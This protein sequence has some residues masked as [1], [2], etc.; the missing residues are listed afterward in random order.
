MGEIPE[1]LNQHILEAYPDNVCLVATNQ[2]DGYS[3]V[4]PRGSVHVVDQD[5]LGYWDRGAGTTHE[6]VQTGTKV[7]V[8][9]RN[10]A[11]GG[12][13]KGLLPAGGIARFYGVA[14]VH[15]E[16][17]EIREKVWNGMIEVEREKD[18]DKTGRAVLVRLEK[19]QQLN[20]KPL[21]DVG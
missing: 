16:D 20:H 3:Q 2:P 15:A 17:D 21:S 7:T 4:S 9:F 8:F 1:V 13:G 5:T 11:L 19:A 12:G 6:T 18:P 10:G 14:E